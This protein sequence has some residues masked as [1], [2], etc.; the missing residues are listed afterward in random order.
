[1]SSPH[2]RSSRLLLQA[3]STGLLERTTRTHRDSGCL[4]ASSSRR[5]YKMTTPRR[6]SWPG[7]SRAS[8]AREFLHRT[9]GS[10]LPEQV[11]TNPQLVSIAKELRAP[12]VATN[13]LHYVHHD[14]AEMHDALLC[15]G[16]GSLVADPNRFRFHSDQHYL[17]SAAE[18]RYLFRELPEACNNTL[19]IAERA[20]VTIEFDTTRCPSSRFRTPFAPPHTK[21][22]QPPA[23]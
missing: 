12:L 23:A 3:R 22:A 17:K 1:V 20:S 14:D 15:I 21:R 5:S 16:T 8:S 2:S 10:R 9:P 13:D 19:L 6:S 4:A 18:M 7:G 11:R